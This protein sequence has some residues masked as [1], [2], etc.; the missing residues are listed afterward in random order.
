MK[1][2][3]VVWRNL[4]KIAEAAGV[5]KTKVYPHNFRHMF[6]R[7]YMNVFGNLV[8]LSDI[9]GHSSVET[10]RIYTKASKETQRRRMEALNL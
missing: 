6:A 2:S 5:E 4:K 9:L 8:E 7:E 10:T 1:N 3:S